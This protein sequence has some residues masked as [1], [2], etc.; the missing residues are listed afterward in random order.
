[1]SSF[2]FFVKASLSHN[3]LLHFG[4]Y[5]GLNLL[6]SHTNV[7]FQLLQYKRLIRVH[8][9]LQIIRNKKSGAVKSDKR[10]GQ[11]IS[12]HLE[13]TFL[14]VHV[15]L[16]IAPYKEITWGLLVKVCR[17]QVIRGCKFLMPLMKC[18]LGSSPKQFGKSIELCVAFSEFKHTECP[19]GWQS[20]SWPL[21]SITGHSVHYSLAK[22]NLRVVL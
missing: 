1:M 5:V 15:I 9:L 22:K 3:I 4:Q 19:L 14:Y 10:A 11:I 20:P 13:I 17:T 6:N 21:L 16:D 7:A 12:I 2:C 18:L 8:C